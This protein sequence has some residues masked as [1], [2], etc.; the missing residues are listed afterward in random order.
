MEYVVSQRTKIIIVLAVCF[1]VGVLGSLAVVFFV[2]SG[3]TT[4]TGQIAVPHAITPEE[5][6]QIASGLANMP[7]ATATTST[8]TRS[9]QKALT[10]AV[11]STS[12]AAA[13]AR[14]V[15]PT[16]A[17]AAKKLYLLNELRNMSK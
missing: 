17:A 12:A 11:A 2:T 3:H 13:E 8:T 14:T 1:A 6:A 4:Q 15:N 7:E 9:L 16:D 10:A 5:K